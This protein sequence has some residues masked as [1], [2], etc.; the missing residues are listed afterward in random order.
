MENNYSS[1]KWYNGLFLLSSDKFYGS[2]KNKMWLK[3]KRPQQLQESETKCIL[4][5]VSCVFIVN[6]VYTRDVY[7]NRAK[8]YVI[9]LRFQMTRKVHAEILIP[10]MENSS[11]ISNY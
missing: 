2:E 8:I 4:R 6:L 9:R 10:K 11:I 7:N 5:L 3:S 1:P